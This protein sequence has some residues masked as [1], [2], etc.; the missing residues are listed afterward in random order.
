MLI[1]YDLII[2]I[3]LARHFIGQRE[4]EVEIQVNFSDEREVEVEV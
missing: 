3:L 2:M 1:I 4:V